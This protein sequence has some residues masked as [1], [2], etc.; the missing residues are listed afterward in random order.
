M[1]CYLEYNF[2]LHHKLIY[3]FHFFLRLALIKTIFFLKKKHLT[4]IQHI[5]KNKVSRQRPVWGK[6]KGKGQSKSLKPIKLL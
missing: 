6:W 4:S 3:K 1:K 5:S 2:K